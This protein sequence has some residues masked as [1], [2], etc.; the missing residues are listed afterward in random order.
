MNQRKL[1][2]LLSEL[3]PAIR[4]YLFP[5]MSFEDAFLEEEA[6][7]KYTCEGRVFYD[8]MDLAEEVAPAPAAAEP[9][10]KVVRKKTRSIFGGTPRME[11]ASNPE[12][13]SVIPEEE[14]LD[15]RTELILDE[16]RRLQEKYNVTI[17]ELEILL[18]YTVKLSQLKIMRSGKIFL[19]DYDNTEVRMPNVAKALFFLYLRHPE[20]LRFKDVADHR[21]EL[22]RIYSNITG[23]DEPEEIEKS[24]D[25][26][27]DPFGNALNVNASRI[28]TAFRNAVSDRIARFYYINGAA[29]DVKKVP[30]DRD[31]VI[32]EY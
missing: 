16:I 10:K 24:I 1:H 18:G 4:A 11:K 20:G 32:W 7:P 26:L 29:G 22:I 14:R 9:E 23:R 5:G 21:E 3:T 27:V 2:K 25:L 28:K 17:D 30:L 19:S 12:P 31:L 8:M 13:V 15:T 6:M